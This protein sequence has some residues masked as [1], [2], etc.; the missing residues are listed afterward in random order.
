MPTSSASP[1]RTGGSPYPADRACTP[2][3]SPWA[4]RSSH[5]A[6]A[7]GVLRSH[8]YAGVTKGILDRLSDDE[9]Q[10]VLAHE[11]SY[12]RMQ[13]PLFTAWRGWSG[14]MRSE[15]AIDQLLE[16]SV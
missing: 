3:P 2:P 12:L 9:L 13:D 16:V 11:V 15:A 1:R 5:N 8:Q 4:K 7:A 14:W 10:A 6:Y